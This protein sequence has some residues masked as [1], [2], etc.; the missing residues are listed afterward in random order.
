MGKVKS[1]VAARKRRD[2]KYDPY[3]SNPLH[4]KLTNAVK[5][6]GLEEAIET[7]DKGEIQLDPAGKPIFKDCIEW[8]T[9][10]AQIMAIWTSI[11]V[12]LEEKIVPP[13]EIDACFDLMELYSREHRAGSTKSYKITV[14]INYF[15]GTWHI[16]NSARM[17]GLF[18]EDKPLDVAVDELT[19]WFA[20]KIDTYHEVKRREDV[21][22]KAAPSDFTASQG[23]NLLSAK[24]VYYEEKQD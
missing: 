17:F 11:R 8:D 21:E 5:G 4:N 3:K 19:L 12:C 9:D 14:P 1:L 23:S 13:N 16:L 2:K 18:K 7:N 6:S 10:S 15:V 24:P 22:D 20:R